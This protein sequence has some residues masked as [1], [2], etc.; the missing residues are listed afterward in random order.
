MIDGE[1]KRH[2]A[3]PGIFKIRTSQIREKQPSRSIKMVVVAHWKQK[4][5]WDDVSGRKI[6]TAPDPTPHAGP[7][8]LS[9]RPGSLPDQGLEHVVRTT[10]SHWL[11]VT[12]V[13]QPQNPILSTHLAVE[14]CQRHGSHA[15]FRHWQSFLVP[16]IIARRHHNHA[17]K[18]AVESSFGR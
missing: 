14:A 2:D 16:V 12:S 10:P 15:Y 13:L 17:R 18:K 7:R 9:A 5:I 4:K 6:D 8:S 1:A 3:I 11:I